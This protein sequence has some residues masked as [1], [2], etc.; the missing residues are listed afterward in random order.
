MTHTNDTFEGMDVEIDGESFIDCRF[1]DC[2]LVYSGGDLPSMSGCILSGSSMFF[3]SKEAGATLAFL[4]RL[5]H[6]GFGLLVDDIFRSIKNSEEFS[7]ILKEG[8]S[9]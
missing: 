1:K 2:R 4:A 6:G 8:R 3:F 5:Y 9:N 7:R